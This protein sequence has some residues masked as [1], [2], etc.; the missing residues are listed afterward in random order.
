M[1]TSKDKVTVTLSILDKEYRIACE[2][3][4]KESLQASAHLLNT[5]IQKIRD[6]GKAIGADRVAIMAALNLTHDL[7]NQRNEQE[8]T[9]NNLNTRICSLRSRI[10]AALENSQQTGT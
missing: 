4:K 1:S 7:L 10:D 5:Y 3:G 8:Y 6:G 2:N 9:T